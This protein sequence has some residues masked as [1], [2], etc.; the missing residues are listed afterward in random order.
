MLAGCCGVCAPGVTSTE[1]AH[2]DQEGK[3]GECL[4]GLAIRIASEKGLLDGM[5]ILGVMVVWVIARLVLGEAE[6]NDVAHVVDACG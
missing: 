4:V 6:K 1:G 2:I 3:L 5:Q